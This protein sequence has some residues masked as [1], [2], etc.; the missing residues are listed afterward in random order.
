MEWLKEQVGQEAVVRL[1]EPRMDVAVLAYV[2]ETTSHGVEWLSH[3]DGR[4]LERQ[5]NTG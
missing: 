2:E 4:V 3:V 5:Q 1:L